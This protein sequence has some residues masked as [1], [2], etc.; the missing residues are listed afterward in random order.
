MRWGAVAC[1]SFLA[2]GGGTGNSPDAAPDAFGGAGAGHGGAAGMSSAGAGGQAGIAGSGGAGTSGGSSGTGGSAGGVGGTTGGSVGAAGVGG[3]TGGSGGAV[4]VG[5]TGGPGAPGAGGQVGGR[6]G[7]AGV[8]GAGGVGVSGNSIVALAIE[9][10]ALVYDGTRNLIYASVRGD[11]A[12]YPNTIVAVDPVT[13]A[14]TSVIPVGSDPGPLALSDDASTLW[15]GLSGSY[16]FRKVTLPTGS[17]PAVVGPLN[18]FALQQS[19]YY[20]VAQSVVAVAG[21]PASVAVAM[22]ISGTIYTDAIFDGGTMRPTTLNLNATGSSSM[23]TGPSGYLFGFG[24][25]QLAVISVTASGLT[26]TQVPGLFSSGGTG[27]YRNG[28]IYATGG[29]AIDTT[30]LAAPVRI[31]QFAFS[32]QVALRDEQHVLMLSTSAFDET[33]VLRIL[34]TEH[35]TQLSA[36]PLPSS[37]STLGSSLYSFVYAGDDCVAFVFNESS[38]TPVPRL[39]LLHSPAIRTPS[40]S[41]GGSGGGGSGGSFG[42]IGGT[43]GAAGSGGA[44]SDCAGCSFV[45]ST[46]SGRHL[47]YDATRNL[48]YVSADNAANANKNSLVVVDPASGSVLSAV[49]LGMDPG[50]LALSDDA[51]TLWVGIGGEHAIQRVALGSPPVA[52]SKYALPMRGTTASTAASLVVLPGTTSSVAVAVSG[53]IGSPG[54]YV[55][56]DGVARATSVQSSDAADTFITRG[57]P[58]VLF[59]YNRYSD[60]AVLEVTDSGVTQTSFR[61]LIAGNNIHTLSYGNGLVF[62]SDGP[63][64][65]V[66]NVDAPVRAG[67]FDFLG[68]AM[69]LRSPTRALMLVSNGTPSINPMLRVFDATMFAT[70]ATATLPASAIGQLPILS[71]M[72]YIGGDAVAFLSYAG[73]SSQLEIMHATAIASPP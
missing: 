46:A 67:R 68:G 20:P 56:D 65:D 18:H 25:T 54:V 63:V 61:G 15:V 10:R 1:L 12:A 49:P 32:G 2:C 11:A 3:A 34:E 17:S 14:V 50:P 35:F 58:G 39:M 31:G 33:A 21:S 40:I 51:S 27:I 13:A 62:A 48:I 70:T 69:A 42:G 59:G 29:E 26:Q 44:G 66:S 37:L 73:N 64:I 28:R 23:V 9:A 41:A 30:N 55:L 22:T 72:V 6:G 47:A 7:Q 53:N 19:Y 36:L 24:G 45:S 57:P 38:A 60:F 71:E 16:A 5:G 43:T 52:G 4:G 8:A